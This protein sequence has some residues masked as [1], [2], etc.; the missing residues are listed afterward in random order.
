M[1]HKEPFYT[2]TVVTPTPTF[3]PSSVLVFKMLQRPKDK[4]WKCLRTN[5]PSQNPE[6]PSL[7]T[8]AEPR[9][10]QSCNIQPRR[11]RR[12]RRPPPPPPYPKPSLLRHVMHHFLQIRESVIGREKSK[13]ATLQSVGDVRNTLRAFSKAEAQTSQK[14]SCREPECVCVCQENMSHHPVLQQIYLFFQLKTPTS[15]PLSFRKPAKIY[16]FHRWCMFTH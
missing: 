3:T 10:V 12:R 6:W 4:R 13:R 9:S 5:H 7:K 15:S 11:R 1:S 14:P 16:L 2:S 8:A